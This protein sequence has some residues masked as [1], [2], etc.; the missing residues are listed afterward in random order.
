MADVFFLNQAL[1][2][3]NH[4]FSAVW[5]LTRAMKKAG[6]T[7][8]GSGNGTTKE[9]T[10]VATA[11]L[12]GG[13][14]DPASDTYPSLDG[15][16][17]WWQARGPSTLKVPVSTNSTGT[18]LRGEKVTQATSGAEGE[19]LGFMYDS[20]TPANSFLVILPRTGTFDG[21]NV[22]TGAGSAATITPSGS[23]V[24]YVAEVVF[25]KG[26]NQT[27][28]TVYY[29]RCTTSETTFTS[30]LGA[31]GCTATVPPGGGGTGNSFPSTAMA[32]R[33]TGGSASH[34]TWVHTTT[35]GNGKFQAVAT[36][37]TG[38]T[39]VSPDGTFWLN[40]GLPGTSATDSCGFG[41]FRCDDTED[42]DLDPFVWYY[43]SSTPARTPNTGV[44]GSTWS[45]A[46]I[47]YTSASYFHGWRRRG[48]ASA[49]AWQNF[50]SAALSSMNVGSRVISD[51][52]ATIESVACHTQTLRVREPVW[53]VTMAQATKMRKGT[54]R[55]WSLVPTGTAYD[56]FDAKAAMQ[57]FTA[58]SSNPGVILGPWDG[59]TSAQ[60][61]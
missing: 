39:N 37:V 23:P 45:A 12:W 14:A 10:G 29:T 27:D 5:K 3:N 25:W 54:L 36:N 51:T 49:D 53:I 9:T 60:N 20:A 11:D 31:A 7:Y 32:P 59:S 18:F 43:P 42:G 58:T 19:I 26:T 56:D 34:G 52:F 33:G 44:S 40:V 1:Q 57:V 30:L 35:T 28:G 4:A 8:M 2:A 15:V 13:S 17:A 61:S 48:F 47:I 21:T 22:I 38:A 55:W 24:E 16:A 50:S 6:W 46:S 41:F